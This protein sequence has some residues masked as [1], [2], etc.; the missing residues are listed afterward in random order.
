MKSDYTDVAIIEAAPAVIPRHYTVPEAAI[1]SWCWKS[2]RRA[3]GWQTTGQVDNYP[4]FDEG[5]DGFELGEKCSGAR[6]VSA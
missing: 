2:C 1:P 3:A 6:S 5:I 4:G